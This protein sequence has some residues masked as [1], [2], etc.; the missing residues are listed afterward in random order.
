VI[1]T[2]DSFIGDVVDDGAALLPIREKPSFFQYS[3]EAAGFV[4]AKIPNI[5]KKK[6]TEAVVVAADDKVDSASGII[7]AVL[8]RDD[9]PRE[10]GIGAVGELLHREFEVRPPDFFRN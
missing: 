1:D 6:S 10:F 2:V 5:V 3:K 9:E 8:D 7:D 4:S